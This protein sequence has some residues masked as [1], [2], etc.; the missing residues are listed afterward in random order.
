MELVECG[1]NRFNL[2]TDVREKATEV[3]N[4]IAVAA[5]E[6]GEGNQFAVVLTAAGDGQCAQTN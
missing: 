2:A 1:G 6:V 3:G 4:Q 5:T